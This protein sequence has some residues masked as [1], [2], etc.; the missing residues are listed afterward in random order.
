MAR[1]RILPKF[2]KV[3][4]VLQKMSREQFFIALPTGKTDGHQSCEMAHSDDVN[5]DRNQ[6]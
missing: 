2:H 4:S 1:F 5:E 3:T 6:Q